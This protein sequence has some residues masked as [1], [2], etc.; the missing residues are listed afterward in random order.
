MNNF[1]SGGLSS[2]CTKSG[3]NGS[4]KRG[5]HSVTVAPAKQLP[6][7]SLPLSA[8]ALQRRPRARCHTAAC[9]VRASRSWHIS[10]LRPRR[11]NAPQPAVVLLPFL[12]SAAVELLRRWNSSPLLALHPIP[13]TAR[14]VAS[15]RFYWTRSRRLLASGSVM[16][17]I[18]AAAAHHGRRAP[19]HRGHT[20]PEHLP[21]P[22]LL[23]CVRFEA[24]IMFG[25]LFLPGT[26][27]TRRNASS[28]SSSHCRARPHRRS[29]FYA[30]SASTI[31]PIKSRW[32]PGRARCLRLTSTA[33]SSPVRRRAAVRHGR[34]CAWTE[35]E[36][37]QPIA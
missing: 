31:K 11:Y 9:V 32:A 3:D 27:R 24:V 35:P 29:R 14:L 6:H 10:M 17:A 13:P 21:H 20:T 5:F 23:R 15:L 34:G 2:C 25:P 1:G 30:V 26:R 36:P 16:R 4:G 22:F 12:C 18:S 28:P 19:S 37:I 7:S 8:A 33:L